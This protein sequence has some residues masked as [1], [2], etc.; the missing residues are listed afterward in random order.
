M[1]GADAVEMED[2]ENE[3][4]DEWI[5]R[6]HDAEDFTLAAMA[7]IWEQEEHIDEA[8]EEA[9]FLCFFRVTSHILF[10]HRKKISLKPKWL[11]LT[12]KSPDFALECPLRSK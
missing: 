4:L 10:Y 3:A 2:F 12:P 5:S 1:S 8:V 7:K 11:R 9:S 6:G